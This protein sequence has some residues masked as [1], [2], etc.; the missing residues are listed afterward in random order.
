MTPLLSVPPDPR[1][2]FSQREK[3]G[4]FV[5]GYVLGMFMGGP[6]EWWG[7]ILVGVVA[8]ALSEWIDIVLS[9]RRQLAARKGVTP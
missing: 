6:P 5:F 1:P 2:T 8:F 9:R 4:S 3:N 7:K